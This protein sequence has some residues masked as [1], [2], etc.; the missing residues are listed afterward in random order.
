L[1]NDDKI[2]GID[3]HGVALEAFGVERSLMDMN[4]LYRIEVIN[5]FNEKGITADSGT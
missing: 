4:T 5:T 1:G 3:G 2:G